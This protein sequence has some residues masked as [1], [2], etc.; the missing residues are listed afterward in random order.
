[1]FQEI[2]D[3]L[4][5]L[6]NIKILLEPEVVEPKV[7]RKDLEKATEKIAHFSTD[8]GSSS[9]ARRHNIKLSIGKFNGLMLKPGEEL[10]FNETTGPRD[11]NKGYKNAPVIAADKSLQDGPGGGVCQSSTTLYNAFLLADLKI[12][13]RA[14][15]SFPSSYVDIGFDA[16]VNWPNLDLKVKNNRKTPIFI[17][18]YVSGNKVHAIIYGEPLENGRTIKLSSEIY[19]TIEAPQPKI[20]KDTKGE[21]VTYTDEQFEKVQSRKGYR[22]KTYQ[23]IYEKGKVVEKRLVANDYYK[24]IQGQIYVGVKERPVPKPTEPAEQ[25]GPEESAGTTE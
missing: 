18:T 7:Y 3:Q 5:A 2:K 1:M 17:Q 19:Q 12:L 24:P 20:I 8:L 21:Y 4:S 14:H 22:V 23:V 10:S 16:T 11:L 15:H 9:S 13:Q 25:A 6:W